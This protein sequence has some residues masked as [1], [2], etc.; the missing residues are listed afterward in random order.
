MEGGYPNLSRQ[1][2]RTMAEVNL[3][4]SWRSRTSCM[5]F[6]CSLMNNRPEEFKTIKHEASVRRKMLEK[7]TC[8]IDF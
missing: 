7:R 3:G 2:S 4:A 1:F 8:I 6:L 5:P